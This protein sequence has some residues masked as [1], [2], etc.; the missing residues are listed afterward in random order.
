MFR[1]PY[2]KILIAAVLLMTIFAVSD[3]A[4]A[5]PETKFASWNIR[6]LSDK[7]RDDTEL[8]QIAQMLVDYD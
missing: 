6:I 4:D 3:L 1:K 2:S 7:S 5:H 8:R